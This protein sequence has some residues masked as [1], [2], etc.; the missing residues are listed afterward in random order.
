[1]GVRKCHGGTKEKYRHGSEQ[2]FSIKSNVTLE[3]GG[4]GMTANSLCHFLPHFTACAWKKKWRG[5]ESIKARLRGHVM[6]CGEDEHRKTSLSVSRCWETNFQIQTYYIVIC[7]EFAYCFVR[8]PHM[9]AYVMVCLK[10]LLFLT[11][12]SVAE[13]VLILGLLRP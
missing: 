3:L 5:D 10:Y 9:D 13:F 4:K 8:C 2:N 12:T 6:G 7:V 1:M 11:D